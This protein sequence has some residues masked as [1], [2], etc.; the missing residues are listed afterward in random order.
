MDGE[1]LVRKRHMLGNDFGLYQVRVG[2][3]P[4]RDANKNSVFEDRSDQREVEKTMTRDVCKI[5]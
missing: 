1:F 3:W 2:L 5:S 4:G